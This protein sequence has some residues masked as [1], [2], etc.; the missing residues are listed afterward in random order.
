MRGIVVWG[1]LVV[2]LVASR[3]SVSLSAW[4]CLLGLSLL[5]NAVI[6]L[7]TTLLVGAGV[8]LEQEQ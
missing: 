8:E 2:S 1:L 5:I 3:G 7:P 4:D 6:Y